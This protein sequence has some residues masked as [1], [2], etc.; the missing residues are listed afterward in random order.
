[1]F[2]IMVDAGN[3]SGSSDQPMFLWLQLQSESPWY[4]RT[5]L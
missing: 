1:M 4:C 5:S 3:S 2:V